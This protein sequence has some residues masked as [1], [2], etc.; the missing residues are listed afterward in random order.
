MRS[1]LLVIAILLSLTWAVTSYAEGKPLV[2]GVAVGYPPYQYK[3]ELGNPSG[4]DVDIAKEVAR[5]LKRD[6]VFDSA[7]WDDVV[8]S[9]RLERIDFISGMEIN[10]KRQVMF[11]FT[12]S[13]YTRKVAVFALAT[14]KAV[15]N[16]YDLKWKVIT[17]DRHS[18][19]EELFDKL[20]LKRQ[21]RIQQT[22]SKDESMLLLKNREVVAMVAPVEVA[23]Q[24][25]RK[26]G[27]RL[28][29]LDDTDPGSPVGIAVSKGDELLLGKIKDALKSMSQDGSLDAILQMWRG[30]LSI[31]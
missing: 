7:P 14:N 5:R 30:G 31:Q 3:D 11:D 21:I 17:G 24:L 26:H 2:C 27:V 8:T 1:T 23:Y 19:V 15:Q 6:I 25:A 29:V 12:G 13:Y 4:L 28:K 18:Y 22:K 9:L 20:D 10:P 16:L